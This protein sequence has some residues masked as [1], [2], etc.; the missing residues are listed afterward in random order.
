MP[1]LK[2][3]DREAKGFFP[4]MQYNRL[5]Q[6][7]LRISVM[8]FGASPLGGVFGSNDPGEG[9]R[10]VHFAVDAGINFFDVSP[11]YGLTLAEERLG[12]A[13]QVDA[14]RWFSVPNAAG[15]VSTNSTFPRNGFAP[16]S[17]NR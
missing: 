2:P 15:T 12:Q 13:L 16:A 14:T 9:A 6:T 11:Y 10:A 4:L 8:G 17:R 1:V 3:M 7:E 5:G